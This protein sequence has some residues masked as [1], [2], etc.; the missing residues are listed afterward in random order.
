MIDLKEKQ[1]CIM[2]WYRPG[3]TTASEISNAQDGYHR[4][5]NGRTTNFQVVCKIKK[6][7]EYA[8][9]LRHSSRASTDINVPQVNKLIHQHKFFTNYGLTDQLGLSYRT[10]QCTSDR[11][12]HEID[13]SKICA[14]C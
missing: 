14:T 1:V 11:T 6:W 9:C 5:N 13:C 4:A 12:D 8:E 10:C 2:S 7:A 3:G